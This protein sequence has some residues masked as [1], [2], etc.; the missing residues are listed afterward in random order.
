MG[1]SP[2]DPDGLYGFLNEYDSV[3]FT[4]A[5]KKG[6]FALNMYKLERGRQ[7]VYHWTKKMILEGKEKERLELYLLSNPAVDRQVYP[8]IHVF[9]HRMEFV[10]DDGA[11]KEKSSEIKPD[12]YTATEAYKRAINEDFRKNHPK[13]RYD[14]EDEAG[15]VAPIFEVPD[16]YTL[17][18]WKHLPRG[19]AGSLG[20]AFFN[21]VKSKPSG[22]IEFVRGGR[23][24]YR[25]K[26]RIIK[27]S[28]K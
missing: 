4:R 20:R 19:L 8:F 13:K 7:L 11:E 21:L 28:Q 5:E 3:E 16:L 23:D 22:E 27:E 26:Y 12:I 24:G 14:K 10:M 18:E 25:A 17:E 15:V 2:F 9:R 1:D 6:C